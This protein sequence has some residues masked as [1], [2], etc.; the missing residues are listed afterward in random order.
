MTKEEEMKGDEGIQAITK[1]NEFEVDP[2]DYENDVRVGG[3]APDKGWGGG[4]HGKVVAL[5]V[6]GGRLGRLRTSTQTHRCIRMHACACRKI[7]RQVS[8]ESA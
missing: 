2:Y 5:L 6:L 8:G 3:V 1:Q 7:W 4:A